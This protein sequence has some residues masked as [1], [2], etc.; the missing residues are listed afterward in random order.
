MTRHPRCA[1]AALLLATLSALPACTDDPDPTP[2]ADCT[3]D[4]AATDA[5][6]ITDDALDD[7]PDVPPDAPPHLDPCAVTLSPAPAPATSS[8]LADA[9]P[10]RT[11]PA[12]RA[13]APWLYD[14]PAPGPLRA[15]T[16]PAGLA[17]QQDRII[18]TIPADAFPDGLPRDHLLTFD[19]PDGPVQR[20][21][22]VY[23]QTPADTVVPPLHEPGPYGTFDSQP[24]DACPDNPTML[25]SDGATIDLFVTWPTLGDPTLTGDGAVAPG[26]W[27]VIVFAHANNDRV[28]DINERYRSLFRHWASYGAIVVAPDGTRHNCQPGSTSNI[29]DRAADQLDALHRLDTLDDDPD[30][31]LYGHLD[32]DRIVLAGHSRGG[33]ASKWGAIVEPRVRAVIDLQGVNYGF[34]N[35]PLPPIPLLGISAGRDV[36]LDYPHVEPIEDHLT[37]PYAWVTLFGGIHAWTADTAPIEP[38]DV[39]LITRPIQHDLTGLFTTAFLAR[40]VGV[41]DGSAPTS[42]AP[43][44]ALDSALFSQQSAD[45][46]QTTISSLGV[47]LRFN[48]DLH[49]LSIDRFN[50]ADADRNDLGGL[51]TAE[52]LTDREVF[53]YLPDNAT[54]NGAN[55]WSR[56]RRLDATTAPGTL[57]FDLAP[58]DTPVPIDRGALLAARIKGP[59]GGGGAALVFVLIDAHGD[60]HELDATPWIGPAPLTNRFVTAVV[61]LRDLPDAV[62]AEGLQRVGLR[63]ERGVLFVDDLRLE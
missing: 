26:R 36:D 28:C 62:F 8:A 60:R 57:W 61:Q 40:F 42:S 27:P 22:T 19:T 43:D 54:A 33:G 41:G 30:S 45:V 34:G 20:V 18:G 21:L 6:A 49:A 35:E 7:A 16:L 53:T 56:S 4:D 29:R 13:G 10:R 55:A 44:P 15:G 17:L 37:G 31:P 48:R 23:P 32:L 47:A 46:A 2:C 38:D 50:D 39:P 12:I 3:T 52:G 51:V 24:T 11:L 63:I 58:D 1:A 9:L 5:D 14:E 59:D 25:A